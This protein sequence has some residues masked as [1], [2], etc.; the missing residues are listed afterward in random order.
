M[1]GDTPLDL[2]WT[3]IELGSTYS[4]LTLQ[5]TEI[6]QQANYRV[7]PNNNHQFNPGLLH[8]EAEDLQSLSIDVRQDIYAKSAISLVST[9]CSNVSPAQLVSNES[10]KPSNQIVFTTEDNVECGILDHNTLM[11]R[12]N[13]VQQKVKDHSRRFLCN[14]KGCNLSFTRAY[15]LNRHKKT[16]HGEGQRFPCPKPSCKFSMQGQRGPFRRKDKLRDHINNVHPDID[17][18]SM[19][20]HQQLLRATTHHDA[21]KETGEHEPNTRDAVCIQPCK[22]GRAS[23]EGT[24]S[25][26]QESSDT[27]LNH[28][29]RTLEELREENRQMQEKHVR[30]VEDLKDQNQWLRKMFE[31]VM[32]RTGGCMEISKSSGGSLAEEAS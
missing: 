31:E 32:K 26:A 27:E 6:F 18:A 17:L 19:S 10:T 9:G 12:G 22:R 15:E 20:R 16:V 29:R 1:I 5:A 30:E 23:F 24:T 13:K 4:A 11:P 3:D 25:E 8:L 28:L 2:L 7:E 21:G 14:V